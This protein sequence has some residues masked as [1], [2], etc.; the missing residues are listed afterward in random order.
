MT[1]NIFQKRKGFIVSRGLINFA[2]LLVYIFIIF[3]PIIAMSIETISYA[4]FSGKDWIGLV[5][6]SQR[7]WGLLSQSILLS[8]LT[9]LFSV[10]IGIVAASKFWEYKKGAAGLL[11]WLVLL[12]LV[13]PPYI[14]THAWGLF[15]DKINNLLSSLN[16]ST[17][18]FQG[19]WASCFVETIAFLPVTAGLSLL[20]M[21]AV[22]RELIDAGRITANDFSVFKNIILP[23]ASRVIAAGAGLVF[24]LSLIDYTIPSLLQFD[25]YALEIF[26]EFSATN[27][28]ARAFLLS[29]PMIIIS[30]IVFGLTMKGLKTINLSNLWNQ[31][32]EGKGF[33]WPYWFL[34]LQKIIMG[35]FITSV[36]VPMVSLVFEAESLGKFVDVVRA[37]SQEFYFSILIAVSTA[38]ISIVLAVLAVWG[39]AHKGIREKVWWVLIGIPLAI[40]A[41]LIGIGLISVWNRQGVLNIYGTE[42]MPIFAGITRFSAIAILVL[43]VYSSRV[44]SLLMDA[45]KVFANN[46]I[47]YFFGIHLPMILPGLI[48]GFFF[49]FTLAIGELGATLI[50]APPGKTTLTM[51]IYNYL[52]YGGTETIA[53]LCLAVVILTMVSGI[54]GLLQLGRRK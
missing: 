14:H 15:I 28:P 23:L 12:L 26:A 31:S 37:S 20:G 54:I 35:I 4:L 36:L 3:L 38:F 19:F 51:K 49:V 30:L 52:H 5:I 53:G 44:N 16:I 17:I 41:P 6:P 11:K 7:K 33:K 50:V 25:L 27:E 9:T 24:L 22:D 42:L 13:I 29:L 1:N 18:A 48:A 45:G 21:M 46:R 40:P 43:Y 34:I 47:R 32:Y 8:G 10:S 39:M 2:I